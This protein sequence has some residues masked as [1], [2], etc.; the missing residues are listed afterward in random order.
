M[1]I[2][3]DKPQSA[4]I[5]FDIDGTLLDE[6]QQIPQSAAQAIARLRDNGHLALLNTGRCMAMINQEILDI[7]FDGVVASCG[8]HIVMNGQTLQNILIPD[9]L[10]RTSI[11]L[12][13]DNNIDFWLE[14]P[15]KVLIE[16][17]NP[18][19]FMR[20]FMEIFNQWPHVFSDIKSHPM[21]VNKFSYQLNHNS[22]FDRVE[23]FLRRHFDLIKHR[24]DN[25][26]VIPQGFS[27]ATGMD[28][29]KQHLGRPDAMTF[30]FGDSL[31]DLD[32]L[33]AADVG[34]A[35]GGSRSRLIQLSNHL[36]DAPAH[37]GIAK[38]LRHYQLIDQ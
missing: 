3:I 8:T 21:H 28:A 32:M 20:S 35:M 12:L 36:T 24:D 17:L 13:I 11:D 5:F 10:L 26:E 34:I 4:L 29:I 25:G 18:S 33:K 14:G 6:R 27:K 30:A 7:G 22:R 16:S 37:D 2:A 19:G 15:D 1:N 31:N 9:D 23:P 38:A